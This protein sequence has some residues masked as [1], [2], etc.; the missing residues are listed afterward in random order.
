MIQVVLLSLKSS[1]DKKK[2]KKRPLLKI[3]EYLSLKSGE[4]QKKRGLY[5]NLALYSVGTVEFIRVNRHF[6]V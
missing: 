6:F 5:R 2:K 1:E 4:N 3:E